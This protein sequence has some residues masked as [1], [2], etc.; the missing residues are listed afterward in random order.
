MIKPSII[1]YGVALENQ[2]AILKEIK[3]DVNNWVT[4]YLDEK[5]GQ[6]WIREHKYPEMHA[7]G[8][9]QLRLIE[10]FPWE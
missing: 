3:V 2:L 9:A 10:M 4:Y 1:L 8:P 6:R 7:G 5:S